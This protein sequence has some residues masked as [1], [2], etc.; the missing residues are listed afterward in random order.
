[1]ILTGKA[2]ED[3]YKFLTENYPISSNDAEK[4]FLA[5]YDKFKN[6]LIIEWFDSVGI[7]IDIETDFNYIYVKIKE[8][9]CD[10][11]CCNEDNC[12]EDRIAYFTF[13]IKNYNTSFDDFYSTNEFE[14]RQEATEK[15][16]IK[17]NEIY[18][19]K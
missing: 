16:I 4:W 5:L 8:C 7:Y 10:E 2:K 1:M 18:N 14:T 19:T 9:N 11:F 6:S 12:Y 15:A 13:I 17:V 3:F